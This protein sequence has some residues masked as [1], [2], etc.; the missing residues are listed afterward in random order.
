MY[1]QVILFERERP[2]NKTIW[3]TYENKEEAIKQAKEATLYDDE[4]YYVGVRE[5][6]C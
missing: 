1:Y 5:T 3:G 6:E 2:E 4:N